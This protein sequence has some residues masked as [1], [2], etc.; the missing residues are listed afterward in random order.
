MLY[1]LAILGQRRDRC[2][3]NWLERVITGCRGVL[4]D[5]YSSGVVPFDGHMRH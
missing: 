5:H 3:V 4:G 1:E 2:G